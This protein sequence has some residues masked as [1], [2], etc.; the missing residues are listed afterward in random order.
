MRGTK[1]E[2]AKNV[3][4]ALMAGIIFA[5][6][7]PFESLFQAVGMG[8]LFAQ[9]VWAL[10]ICYDEIQRQRRETMWFYK[11]RKENAGL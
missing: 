10:L 2:N 9:L 11:K 8:Y 4:I 5:Q 1:R 7:V 3:L 6:N